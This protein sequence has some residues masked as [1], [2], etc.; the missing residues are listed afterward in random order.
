M[1]K[2]LLTALPTRRKSSNTNTAEVTK[3]WWWRWR[4]R[5]RWRRSADTAEVTSGYRRQEND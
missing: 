1:F 4:R 5:F 2:N 3:R